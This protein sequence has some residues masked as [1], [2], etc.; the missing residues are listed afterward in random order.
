MQSTTTHKPD[1]S[2]ATQHVSTFTYETVGGQAHLKSVQINDGRPRTVTYRTDL[3]GQVIRRDEADANAGGDPHE[4]WHRF[5]GRQIGY[6]SNNGAYDTGYVAS[7]ETRTAEQGTGAFR[8]GASYGSRVADFDQGV[9]AITSYYQGEAGGAYTVRA[10]DTLSSIAANIWGDSSLWYKLAEANGMSAQ[11]ALS[12]GQVLSIPAG[13]ARATYNASTF[14]PYDPA[15]AIGDVGPTTPVQPKPQANKCGAFGQVLLVVVA[16]VVTIYT[17]GAASGSLGFTAGTT[18]NAVATGAVAGAAGSAASQTVGVATGIQQ[19][20]SWNAVALSGISGGI[21]GGIGANFSGGGSVGAAGRAVAG[22]VIT[23]GIGVATGLQSNFSWAGVAAVGVGGAAAEAAFGAEALQGLADTN[24]YLS[25]EYIGAS[26]TRGTASALASAATRTLIDGSD[27]GDNILAALPDVIG[28][29]IGDAVGGR[30]VELTQENA[31][32]RRIEDQL[33]AYREEGMSGPRAMAQLYAD[34]FGGT[35]INAQDA[36]PDR[37]QDMWIAERLA[38]GSGRPVHEVYDE[39]RAVQ[40][41]RE[42]SL[43][44][45]AGGAWELAVNTIDGIASLLDFVVRDLGGSAVNVA[46]GGAWFE[47]SR[48]DLN[49]FI[50]TTAGV[51]QNTAEFAALA[52]TDY[53]QFKADVAQ[54]GGIIGSYYG[55]QKELAASLRAEGRYFEAGREDPNLSILLQAVTAPLAAFKIGKLA[56]AGKLGLFG[57]LGGTIRNPGIVW[58]KGIAAQGAPW[59]T[60]LYGT[61]RFGSNL[62]VAVKPNFAVFD[63]F[64]ID[65]RVATSAKTLDLAG[66]SYL[67]AGGVESRI[68]TMINEAVNFTG[69]GRKFGFFLDPSQISARRIELAVPAT[70]SRAQMQGIHNA[71]R[72]GAGLNTPVI[73]NVT[74]I[75]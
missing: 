59:E 48:N 10:G 8:N 58:G 62:N 61:G 56:S 28:Q 31:A 42:G 4:V 27:F 18:G 36:G 30:I 49:D 9:E 14:T 26:L 54:I 34:N 12:E 70:A 63:F 25:A 19:K 51:A 35:A 21:G 60:F 23:Q 65:T 45:F 33:A 66:S 47:A 7:I 6:V 39:L 50:S 2:Q 1:T 40:G 52:F 38:R 67:T 46:S 3:F 13:A 16:V 68:K 44:E 17:A 22:N 20:F 43:A 37:R 71:T 72:Y 29:T 73:V 53:D 57:R 11:A 15:S 55:D 41:Y 75:R 69:D 32:R 74:R 5:A 24:G 64:D